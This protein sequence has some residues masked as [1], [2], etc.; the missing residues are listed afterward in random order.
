MLAQLHDLWRDDNLTVWLSGIVLE[1]FLMVVFSL[2]ERLERH[3]LRYDLFLPEL[4]RVRFL[5]GFLSHS[6]LFR[7]VVE[8]Y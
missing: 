3:N 1:I 2:V 6:L 7:I 4:R 5:D 8:D